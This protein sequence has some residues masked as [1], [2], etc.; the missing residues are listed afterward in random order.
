MSRSIVR[1]PPTL[2]SFFSWIT[3]SSLTCMERGISPISSRKTVP[4]WAASSKPI[5]MLSAPVNAPFSWPKS[6]FA[7]NSSVKLPQLK[8][9]KGLSFLGLPKWIARAVNSLPVPLSPWIRMWQLILETLFMTLINSR[10]GELTPMIPLTWS[11]LRRP[12]LSCLFSWIR[13]TLSAARFTIS[14]ACS[15]VKGFSM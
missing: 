1:D 7:I 10:I 9:I 13:R 15:G 14:K 12:A 11:L 6:S 3:L 4:P 8:L 5:L 2:R